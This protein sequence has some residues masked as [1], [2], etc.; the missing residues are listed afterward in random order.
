MY[1]PVYLY[2]HN[3]G[4]RVWEKTH[5]NWSFDA[6]REDYGKDVL[7]ILYLSNIEVEKIKTFCASMNMT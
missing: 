1:Y 4:A 2:R 7:E 6:I 3:L 5:W